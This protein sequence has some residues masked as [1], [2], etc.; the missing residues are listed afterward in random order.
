[1]PPRGGLTVERVRRLRRGLLVFAALVAAA[2][3]ALYYLG[4]AARPEADGGPT[5]EAGGTSG[6]RSVGRGFDH[7]V[8]HEGKPLLRIRGKRDRR[9]DQGNLHVEEV[10]IGAFQP[11]GTRYEIAADVATYNLEKREGRLT[12]NVSLTGPD[13]FTLRTEGL[14]LKNAGRHLESEKPVRF[15]YGTKNPLAGR[16]RHLNALLERGHFV[17]R[18][19]VE[20]RAEVPEE[21][22]P[23]QLNT[24]R[25]VFSRG[26]HQ[27]RAEGKVVARWGKSR[28]RADRLAA[29]LAPENR[30]LQFLRARWNAHAVFFDQDP[31]GRERHLIVEGDNVTALFDD[32]GR[33]P[34]RLEVEGGRGRKAHLRRAVGAASET[35][36]VV[37]SR[38]EATLL[39]GRL[40]G[41]RATGGVTVDV[42]EPPVR[43]R[44][45]AGSLNAELAPDGT[46]SRTEAQGKV[47]MTE[48]AQRITADRVVATPA[49]TEAFGAPVVLVNER[50]ELRAPR[51]L[52]TADSGVVHAMGGVEATMSQREGGPL[53]RT[54]LVEGD[55][56]IR[57]QAAEGFWNERPR[58][59]FVFRGKARAW[60][61]DRVL[62]AEQIRGDVEQNRLAASGSVETVWFVPPEE[63]EA[64]PPQRVRVQADEM[65]YDEPGRALEFS[66]SVRVVD[67][68]RNLRAKRLE[69]Q[70]DEEGE[71][72]RMIASGEVL[73]EAPAEGR[74]ITAERPAH[75][76][77]ADQV[78]FQG[79]PVVLEDAKGGTLRGAQAVYSTSTGKVRVTGTNEPLPAAT[80]TP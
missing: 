71:A 35:F 69:V 76:L 79:S 77:R 9:D 12:G 68:Q 15:R 72:R 61:G 54:P 45:V 2:I 38:L 52:Y 26:M 74:K 70:L 22:Q 33:M 1:M 6:A 8:T 60:S 42:T 24:E 14:V 73:L 65:T 25:V 62:R 28:L 23:F 59:S 20:V 63:G 48:G 30:R 37:A 39:E 4:R 58:R 49:T 7:T 43:R 21:E 27:L 47:V 31:S 64:G 53:A 46:L 78:V 40:T 29:H 56:P 75:D 17:L 34:T 50:G 67:G 51:L 32:Q 44:V 16:A 80:P 19:A 41:A 11:D 36:D 57:V 5:G 13:G 10:L 3:A 66:G 18:G 55:E